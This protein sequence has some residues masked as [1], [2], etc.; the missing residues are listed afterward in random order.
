MNLG[1]DCFFLSISHLVI[2][3]CSVFDLFFGQLSLFLSLIFLV[4]SVIE[5]FVWIVYPLH[6]F[7]E[8]SVGIYRIPA[9]T[10]NLLEPRISN[11]DTQLVQSPEVI[12]NVVALHQT[13]FEHG[14]TVNTIISPQNNHAYWFRLLKNVDMKLELEFQ[15]LLIHPRIP[16]P[17][18][19]L[20][21]CTSNLQPISSFIL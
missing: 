21:E 13:M 10:R 20:V 2:L 16:P 1:F 8:A 9:P 14:S 19:E 15:S 4:I 11:V 7:F 6:F 17:V 5:S 18:A 3:F 12:Y